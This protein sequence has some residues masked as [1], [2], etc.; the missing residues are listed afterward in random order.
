M[1]MIDNHTYISGGSAG[2]RGHALE[3]AADRAIYIREF[4]DYAVRAYQAAKHSGASADTLRQIAAYM[5][6]AAGSLAGEV[7]QALDDEGI[8]EDAVEIDTSELD[9]LC[10]L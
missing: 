4:I 6:D 9:A 7:S 10:A 5:H 2:R 1:T 8:R 3:D